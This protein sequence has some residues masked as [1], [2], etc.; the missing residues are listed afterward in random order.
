MATLAAVARLKA[1]NIETYL[2]YCVLLH[3]HVL[4]VPLS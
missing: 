4:A 3:F 1:L 2:L